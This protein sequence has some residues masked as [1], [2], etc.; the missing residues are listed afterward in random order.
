MLALATAVSTDPEDFTYTLTQ[1]RGGWAAYVRELLPG[2]TH[3]ER[4]VIT[5]APHPFAALQDARGWVRGLIG[6]CERAGVSLMAQPLMTTRM[7]YPP[8]QLH[9]GCNGAQV[10]VFRGEPTATMTHGPHVWAV[11]DAV[12]GMPR[13]DRVMAV[14]VDNRQVFTVPMP[15][16]PWDPEDR[17]MPATVVNGPFS[18]VCHCVHH[19]GG[20]K[21]RRVVIP[22]H[23]PTIQPIPLPFVELL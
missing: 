9:C 21:H 16:P 2:R 19:H 12:D 5:G 10:H 7:V 6:A 22:E 1:Q 13:I 4:P 23:V 17:T 3:P 15:Y 18:M 14:D 11:A 20:V 8:T